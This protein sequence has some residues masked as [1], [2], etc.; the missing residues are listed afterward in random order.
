MRW[1]VQELVE[2]VVRLGQTLVLFCRWTHQ[3]LL[4]DFF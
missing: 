4:M 1:L 2:D 3:D